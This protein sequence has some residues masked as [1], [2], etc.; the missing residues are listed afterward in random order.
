[1]EFPALPVELLWSVSLLLAWISGELAYRWWRLPRISTYALSGF[2]LGAGQSG[3]LPDMGS[4]YVLLLANMAFGLILFEAG[5]RI[6]LRWLRHNPWI[7]VS[8]IVEALTTF[9]VVYLTAR[10]LQSSVDAALLIASLSMAS[11]PATVLRVV[12]ELR[13]SGQVTERALHLSVLNCILAVLMFKLLV[14]YAIFETSGNLLDASYRSLLVLLGS[15]TIGALF[16]VA[17]PALLRVLGRTLDDATLVFA[18]SVILLVALTH[19][20]KLSP[21]L[22]TL[23]FGIVSRDRRMV[24]GRSQ[25]GFGALG[26]LLSLL[27]FVAVAASI[28]WSL[29]ASGLLLGLAIVGVRFLVKLGVLWL[30]AVPGGLSQRK[31]LL[32]GLAIMP[33]SVFVILVLEQTRY[34]GI[35]L[36][37][38]LSAL[39]AAALLLEVLGPVL[40]QTALLMAHETSR[41]REQ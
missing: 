23:A 25:R 20:L 4:G 34:L 39:A 28:H 36:V 10:W 33:F 1:M 7:A 2:L 13:S 11:S 41:D 21:L 37:D 12:N 17:L 3:V 38:Q 31:G 40:T 32:T 9:V 15:A 27:L 22:A 35:E 19:F 24:L 5:H 6:N 26:D 14:G 30:F 16:G 18:I 29:V 8:G